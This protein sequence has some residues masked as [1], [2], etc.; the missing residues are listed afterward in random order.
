MAISN[1]QGPYKGNPNNSR[2]I[3]LDCQ[4]RS[5]RERGEDPLTKHACYIATV[6]MTSNRTMMEGQEVE[7]REGK[8]V[9]AT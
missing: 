3:Q 5:K 7:E 6:T 4:R 2:N 1:M 9:K 8:W